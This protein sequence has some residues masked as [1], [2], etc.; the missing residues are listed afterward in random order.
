MNKNLL[1]LYSLIIVCVLGADVADAQNYANKFGVEINGGLNEYG[2]DRGRRYFNMER[3]D[4]Q[5]VGASFGYYINP[6]FDGILFGGVGDLGHRDDSYPVKLGFTARITYVEL[7]LRYKFYNGYLMKETSKIKPYLYAGWGGLNSVSRIITNNPDIPGNSVNRTM[8]AAHWSAGGGVRYAITD[9][10]D[11]LLQSCFNY[12]YDDNYDGLPYSTSRL[13]LNANHDAFLYHSIGI[14]YNFGQNDAAYRFSGTDE[15]VPEEIVK[16]VNLAAT[17]IEFETGSATISEESFASLDTIAEVL[18][19]YPAL[20]TLIEGHTDDVGDDESNMEL[21][22]K[23]AD[24]VKAYL[25]GKG[26]SE[27]RMK[28]TGYG[29]TQP[30]KKNNSDENRAIN[31]RVEVKLYYKN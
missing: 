18:L 3:E 30:K 19:N 21:S 25:A 16:K 22:Q 24:A 26:V 31:R 5:G 14:A 17:S 2:G 9:N 8:T 12:T 7:G 13:R 10:F 6:S 28:A 20:Q 1:A 29:E 23:R 4:Y 15:E 27:S 11:V